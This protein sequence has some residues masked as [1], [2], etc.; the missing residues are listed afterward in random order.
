MFSL[1]R[2]GVGHFGGRGSKTV[3]RT[4]TGDS[5]VQTDGAGDQPPSVPPGGGIVQ[6]DSLLDHLPMDVQGEP[7]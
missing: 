6:G 4:I 3:I 5:E 7:Q 1:R 2:N